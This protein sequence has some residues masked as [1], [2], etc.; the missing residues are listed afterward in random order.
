MNAPF[1]GKI[2]GTNSNAGYCL[3]ESK[4]AF[5]LKRLE[6]SLQNLKEANLEI[7]KAIQL[8][9][10]MGDVGDDIADQVIANL[11]EASAYDDD[12]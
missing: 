6:K 11:A 7:R 10:E 1:C 8:A 4:K 5:V 9:L 2:K 3:V 12:A